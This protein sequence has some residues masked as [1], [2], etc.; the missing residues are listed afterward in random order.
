MAP[1]YALS[2]S[3]AESEPEQPTAPSDDALE[4]A[5]R[6]TVAEI[7][8]TGNMEELTVKRVRL[9]AEKSL[10]LEPGFFKADD[11]WKAKS[12]QII[13][14]AV[15]SQDNASEQSDGDEEE[16]K[17][18]SPPPAKSKP[19]KRTKPDVS[20]PRKRRKAS[21]PDPEEDNEDGNEDEEE[22]EQG[23]DAPG[24]ESEE[25]AKKP[26]KGSKAKQGKK[27]QSKPKGKT[28]EESDDEKEEDTKPSEEQKVEPKD[29]SESEM[30]VVLDEEPQPTRKR[31]KSSETAAPKGKKKTAPKPKD[32]D[33]D[34]NEAEIKRLQGWLVKCGIRKMWWRELAPY[35]TPKAKIKHLK[36]MLK[37][38][39][40][41]G[42]YSAEKANRIREER[43]LRAD[44]EQ[45][46]EGA[47]RWGTG[48]GDDGS[49]NA[50]PRRRLNR[51]RQTL[52]FLD[53]DGEETD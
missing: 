38:A 21:I 5:L 6:D 43:E 42:R 1:R 24:D 53:S 22:E 46:Q 52:A 37:D 14:E 17:A 3:E 16:K 35:D 31:Q 45:V 33:T 47:K 36:E 30:S 27:S 39:G 8:K 12:E 51:G 13:R 20:A 44:L 18:P 23:S 50:Q 10:E 40:M 49:D 41:E 4:K 34:P 19:A 32:A 9:A 11:A 48:S 29:E 2:D 15:E 7:Y 28:V 25:K 26:T